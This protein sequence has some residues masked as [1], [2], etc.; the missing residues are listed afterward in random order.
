VLIFFGAKLDG[1]PQHLAPSTASLPGRHKNFD[2]SINCGRVL[3]CAIS[4]Q[5]NA[6]SAALGRQKNHTHIEMFCLRR[7]SYLP[8][9]VNRPLGIADAAPRADAA[10]VSA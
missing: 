5:A 8:A 1:A 4:V 9:M 2:Y 6:G 3:S 10:L 7:R